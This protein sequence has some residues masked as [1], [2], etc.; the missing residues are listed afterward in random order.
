MS[1][2][3]LFIF[4]TS[5]LLSGCTLFPGTEQAATDSI[6]PMSSPMSSPVPSMMPA[7]INEISVYEESQQPSAGD[8][9]TSLE[10]D[11][12]ATAITDE[13]LSDIFAE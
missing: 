13:D 9:L 8:D 10:K 2:K 5:I 7:D 1:K 12:G 4:L 11:L 6:K 3:I